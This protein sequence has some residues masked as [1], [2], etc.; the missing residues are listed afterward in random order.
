MQTSRTRSNEFAK[1]V[2]FGI[3]ASGYSAKTNMI[4]NVLILAGVAQYRCEVEV[5]FI[6]YSVPAN[7]LIRVKSKS[8][9]MKFEKPD[10]EIIY[11]NPADIIATSGDD[12]TPENSET[13]QSTI[14]DE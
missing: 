5:F 1:I 6:R 4:K 13:P 14:T 8:R 3:I 11:L 9:K 2:L 12:T 10:V 7:P